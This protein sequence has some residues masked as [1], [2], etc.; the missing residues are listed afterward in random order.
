MA[1]LSLYLYLSVREK[2]AT[3]SFRTHYCMFDE[4]ARIESLLLST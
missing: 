1:L 2:Q 3:F 4:F